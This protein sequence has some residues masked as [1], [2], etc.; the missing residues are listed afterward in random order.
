MN[1]PGFGPELLKVTGW[2]VG[3]RFNTLSPPPS[4]SRLD[5]TWYVI[6][7][8][9]TYAPLKRCLQRAARGTLELGE[10]DWDIDMGMQ[11]EEEEE[12]E[13]EMGFEE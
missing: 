12:E 10:G 1:T 4:L 8:Q 2:R 3:L 11:S 5:A 13:D 9:R 7:R 6:M